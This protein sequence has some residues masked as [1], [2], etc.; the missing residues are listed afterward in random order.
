MNV[1]HPGRILEINPQFTTVEFTS[2]SGCSSCHAKELCGFGESGDK[3]I[4][5]PTDPYDFREVGAEVEV[6]MKQSMGLKAVWIS[7]VIPLLLLMA[8]VLVANAFGASE[9]VCGLSGLVT[10]ALYYFV[11]WLFRGKLR[12]EF[13]FELK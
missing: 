11:V 7:Y 3:V 1:T 8:A 13:V 12:N 9:L 6:L 5:L 4:Q 2:H 10:V